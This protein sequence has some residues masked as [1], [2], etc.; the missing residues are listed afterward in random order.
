MLC[1]QLVSRYAS[2]QVPWCMPGSL[3]SDF[4]WSRWW[5]KRSGK[6]GASATCMFFFNENAWIS[7]KVSRKFIFWIQLTI[8]QHQFRWWLGAGQVTSNHLKKWSLVYWRIY[9][10][11][12]LNKLTM[13]WLRKWVFTIMTP[14][15]ERHRFDQ[16]YDL[17]SLFGC[18]CLL[19]SL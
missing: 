7:H 13:S 14:L 12:S 19:V 17:M 3:T 11:L 8:S 2:R 5:G 16:G 1:L 9:A 4:L 15:C 10:W 18:I 6:P